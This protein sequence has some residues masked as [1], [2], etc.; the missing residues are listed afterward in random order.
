ML[1][2]IFIRQTLI[3]DFG[4]LHKN[5]NCAFPSNKNSIKHQNSPAPNT[6][7]QLKTVIVKYWWQQRIRSDTFFNFVKHN[8]FT[9]KKLKGDI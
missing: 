1:S 8:G 5:M 7:N 6:V 2:N 9:N 4:G 3:D